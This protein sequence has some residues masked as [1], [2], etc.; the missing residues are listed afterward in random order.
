VFVPWVFLEPGCSPRSMLHLASGMARAYKLRSNKIVRYTVHKKLQI[1][2]Y[3]TGRI[4]VC[5]MLYSL[6]S[7]KIRKY[8]LKDRFAVFHM[9]LGYL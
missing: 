8:K 2:C 1:D 3:C 6:S 5:V 4:F 7:S 9:R